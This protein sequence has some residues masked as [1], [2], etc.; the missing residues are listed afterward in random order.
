MIS[1]T[2]EIDLHLKASYD[3]DSDIKPFQ[4]DGV[5]GIEIVTEEGYQ[6]FK[7]PTPNNDG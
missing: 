5:K 3:H 6:Y 2:N 4:R 1:L 7:N